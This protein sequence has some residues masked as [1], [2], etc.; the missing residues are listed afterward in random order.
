MMHLGGLSRYRTE[1]MG[2]SAVLILVCHVYAYVEL[3]GVMRYMLSLCNIGVDLFLFLSGMGIWYSLSNKNGGV[4][5]W[6]LNR[7]TKL[8][9]PY[10]VAL[11][12]FEIIQFAFGKQ[13]ENGIWNYLFGLSSLRFYV[14]HDAAWFIAALIPLY[15]LAPLFYNLIKEFQWKAA[16]LLVLILYLSLLV[17]TSF[18]SE[19]L[20][21]VI[22]NIQFVTI[23]STCFVMG[24]ALGQ[25]VKENKQISMWW[26]IGLT[27]TGI[28][29][30]GITRHLVYG[31][32]FFTLPLLFAFLYIIK[33]SRMEVIIFASFMGMISLESYI[34]NGVLPKMMATVMITLGWQTL[35]GIIPYVVACLLS[36]PLGYGF[37]KISDKI[38]KY[39]NR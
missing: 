15:L 30:I 12:P 4:K 16:I 3:P 25:S 38:L 1:L 33:I 7:Y 35:G 31:Y 27:I 17:P 24:M 29:M 14:S 39:L 2:L 28:I 11:I 8:F 21:K 32:L 22:E 34:L 5:Y 26:L 37:Y 19:M 18:R 9:V 23:R 6:Y 10:F 36:M 20:N 13:L